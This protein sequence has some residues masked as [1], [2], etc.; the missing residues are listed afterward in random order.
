[1][2]GSELRLVERQSR[3][4][5]KSEP[6]PRSASL[7]FD[8]TNRPV[9]VPPRREGAFGT[10]EHRQAGTSAVLEDNI[11]NA[12]DVS[13]DTGSQQRAQP[14]PIRWLVSRHAVSAAVAAVIAAE[15]GMGGA[16]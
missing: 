6:T 7:R 9:P 10:E 3:F 15:R 5:T 2:S 1:M 12:F 16:S 11:D 8:E 14:Y 4:W 13:D